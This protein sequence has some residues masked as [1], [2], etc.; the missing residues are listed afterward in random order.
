MSKINVGVL[1][2]GPSSEYEISLKTGENV[3]RHL[4]RDKYRVFDLLLSKSG[5]W[6]IDGMASTPDKIF[7]SLDVVFNALHGEFGEDGRAQK[8]FDMYGIS[9]TGSGNWASFMAMNKPLARETFREAGL[10][11]PEGVVVKEGDDLEE[12]TYQIARKMAPSWVVKPAKRGSSIGISIAHDIDGLTKAIKYALTC[13]NVAIVEKHIAGREATC[14]VVESFRDEDYYTFPVVEIIPPNEA[15]FFD[16]KVKYN[17]KTK[18]IC[19]GRFDMKT[20]LTI[21]D[22]AR[23]AHIALG[24]KNYS[25]S[26]FIVARDGVYLLETNTLPG[27]TAESL[28]PK[29]ASAIGL[30]FPQL[31]DHLIELARQKN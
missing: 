28:L 2:G 27:L 4:S 30:E 26:D 22:M 19:P 11:V 14:G 23:R 20:K 29:A 10:R 18:E 25:R 13:D 1:R 8:I 17:G 15:N 21:Q 16:Y 24:C 3:I 6:H 7:R 5:E 9:Y 31:L 12:A